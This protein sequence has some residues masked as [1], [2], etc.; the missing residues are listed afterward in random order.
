M[1]CILKEVSLTDGAD[2]YNMLRE[3]GPGENGFLNDGNV[4]FSGF[5]VFLQNYVNMSLG[6]NLAN[7]QVAQTLYWLYVDNK[8]VGYGK[9]RHHLNDSLRKI[10][11]HIGYAIRPSERGKGYGK[12]ILKELLLKAKEKDIYKVLMTTTEDN[13]LSRKVIEGNGGLLSHISDGE[14][15][16]CISI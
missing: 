3:I 4:E 6:I 16:Y 10:G 8:P 5:P 9:L 14:C 13:T 7:N 1:N 15:Y 2:I 11:G 12:L